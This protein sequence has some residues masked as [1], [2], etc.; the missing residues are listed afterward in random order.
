MPI[1][2]L[3]LLGF[4][5]IWAVLGD[6]LEASPGGPGGQRACEED[7]IGWSDVEGGH[8]HQ[9]VL[10]LLGAGSICYMGFILT[11]D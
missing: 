4:V 8:L 9:Q 5:R 1:L 11:V 6:L 3:F 2:C 10:D 7:G